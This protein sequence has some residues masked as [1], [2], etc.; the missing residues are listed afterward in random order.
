MVPRL[1]VTDSLRDCETTYRPG[2]SAEHYLLRVLRLQPGAKVCLFD[3]TGGT[4]EGV[5]HTTAGSSEIRTLKFF[6]EERESPLAVT[7]VHGLSRSAAMEWVVQKGTE[8]GVMAIVPLLTRRSVSRPDARQAA[9]KIERWQR[10]AIEASEQCGRTRVP[11]IHPP[12]SW[13]NL[14]ATI[15]DGLRL[16]F[17][18]EQCAGEGLRSLSPPSPRLALT[19]LTGPE[20]GLTAEEVAFAEKE[21]GFVS[22]TL[23]PRILRTETAAL[24]TLTMVQTLWG[25]LG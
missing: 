1:F 19:L 8:L 6:P 11:R 25:D 12:T 13:D 17:W 22:I 9:N 24:A 23:G 15:P 10:I 4:W 20:G 21:L 5:L 14:A 2:R 16:L 7:L 3:G 18:E